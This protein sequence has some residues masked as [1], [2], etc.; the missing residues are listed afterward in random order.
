MV[1][2]NAEVDKTTRRQWFLELCQQYVERYLGYSE[3]SNLVDQTNYN[4]TVKALIHAVMKPVHPSLFTIPC[5]SGIKCIL[6]DC[7]LDSE[8]DRG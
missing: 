6:I 4:N 7:I 3:V 8:Y 1:I 5:V 2:P